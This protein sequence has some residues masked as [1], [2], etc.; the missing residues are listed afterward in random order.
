MSRFPISRIISLF[1]S[2]LSLTHSVIVEW[3]IIEKYKP[4]ATDRP[5]NGNRELEDKRG[6]NWEKQYKNTMKVSVPNDSKV[7]TQQNLTQRN[8]DTVTP[9]S[10]VAIPKNLIYIQ[11]YTNKQTYMWELRMNFINFVL[12]GESRFSLS[13]WNWL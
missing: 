11:I 6:E 13:L 9:K 1:C 12:E 3:P 10:I 2:N 8:A 7:P 5:S 4:G